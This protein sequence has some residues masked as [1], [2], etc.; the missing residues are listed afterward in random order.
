MA[1]KAE[2]QKVNTR[3]TI[4]QLEQMKTH[5]LADLLANVVLVLKRMPNVECRELAMSFSGGEE[6]GGMPEQEARAG[7]L[8]T[9]KVKEKVKFSA[10]ELEAK[11]L[12]EIKEIAKELHLT[13]LSKSTKKELI[14]KI[15]VRQEQEY[16]DQ[17]A[18]QHI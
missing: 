12:P 15:L 3:F 18:I 9:A 7:V 10:A 1:K 11:K 16:S 4:E 14:S 5:E 6:D 2:V 8:E 17:F 13:V